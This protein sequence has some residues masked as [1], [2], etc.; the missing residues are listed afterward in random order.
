[1]KNI[2]I[3]NHYIET[4]DTGK[5]T[6]H[7][8][9]A[10]ELVKKG[11]KVKLFT[12]STVHNTNINFIKDKKK[13]I[14][15]KVD[16]LSFVYVKARDYYGNGKKRALNMLDYAFRLLRIT[17]E[18]TSNENFPDVI[19]ASS[20]HLLTCISAILIAKKYRVSCVI[21]IR[22][23]WPLTFVGMGK[24]REKQFI[25]KILY[26]L[27]KWIYIKADRLIFTMEGGKEYIKDKGWENKVDLNKIYY[28]NNGVDLEVFKRNSKE[29]TVEDDL[30]E[31]KNFKVIYA[32]A[33]GEANMVDKIIK[34]AEIL[35]GKSYNNI[36]FLL[37]G[38][39]PKKKELE[40]YVIKNQISNVI[41]KGRV[42]KK[43]IPFILKSG[44]L[45]ITTGKNSIQYKYGFSQNKFFEYLASGKPILSNRKY[46]NI[47]NVDK[48]GMTTVN[49]SPE[50]LADGI[51]KFYNMP[52]EE[53]HVYT[54]NALKLARKF[55]FKILA[56][57]L[58]EVLFNNVNQIR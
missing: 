3:L 1:M 16:G 23:L 29:Y 30:L 53:Y 22:D 6:R 14:E 46:H 2:W 33:I 24:I 11:Y 47:L 32:G 10:K 52:E 20:P 28:I 55:E 19:Y 18:I 41:F 42:E 37:Y 7:Y 8:T 34:T 54:Q 21:E 45:N 13:F 25:T 27:E 15:K 44:Q 39:G 31:D 38:D 50:A 58:E 51:L 5:Y 57:K 9:F 56:N 17:K 43:Y 26:E 12:A 48:C 36:K 49:E 40:E 4:P 35:N